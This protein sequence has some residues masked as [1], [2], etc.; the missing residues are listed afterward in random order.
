MPWLKHR[1][2][3][4]DFRI[5][6]TTWYSRPK[7]SWAQSYPCRQ[8]A[9]MRTERK[10]I[11]LAALFMMF[12]VWPLPNRKSQPTQCINTTCFAGYLNKQP[13]SIQ[14]AKPNSSALFMLRCI[15]A[16][17]PQVFHRLVHGLQVLNP[18]KRIDVVERSFCMPVDVPQT[19]QAAERKSIAAGV[20]TGAPSLQNKSVRVCRC[21]QA[22]WVSNWSWIWMYVCSVQLNSKKKH[23]HP[24][25]IPSNRHLRGCLLC[26]IHHWAEHHGL[27]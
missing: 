16:V 7:P 11:V 21:D 27:P 6:G 17:C 4:H 1:Y 15:P 14:V 24:Q 20:K 12:A 8:N 10:T 23:Y 25:F 2:N 18:D 9:D 22:I 26:I 5:L 13:E 19:Q 3:V